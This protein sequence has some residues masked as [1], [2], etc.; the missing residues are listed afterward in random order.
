MQDIVTWIAGEARWLAGYLSNQ[1]FGTMLAPGSSLSLFSLVLTLLLAAFLAVPRGRARMP[2]WRVWHR[3]LFPRRMIDTA[4]GRADI[5]WFAFSLFGYG[6]MFGWALVSSTQIAHMVS[7]FTGTVPPLG[8][9]PLAAKVLL[10]LVLFVAFEFAYWLDHYL[11]HA[12]PLLWQFHRVHH[13]AKSLSLLT[14]FRVH[15]V[16]TIVYTN[17]LA[18]VLGVTQGIAAPALGVPHGWTIGEVNVLVMISAIGLNH[19]QHSHLWI[20][21]GPHWGQWLLSP[22]HHQIHHSADQRHHNRNFGSTLALFDRLFG[23]LHLPAA[24][25]EPLRFGLG[26]EVHDPHGW[27][28]ALVDPLADAVA[29]IPPLP[30]RDRARTLAQPLPPSAG[31]PDA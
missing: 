13:S 24:R 26:D 31:V 17:I 21:F 14:V 9:P 22:A 29:L 5:A 19:L 16:D 8:L 27:R 7:A 18:V 1:L 23:T 4:S 6:L 2:R 10:T 25:R 30:G 28:A 3:A 11:S 20:T 12:V 15:P